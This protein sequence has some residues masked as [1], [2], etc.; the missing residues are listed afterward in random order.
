MTRF[1]I[2]LTFICITFCFYG[3]YLA[4]FEL[5]AVNPS[6]KSNIS[7]FNDYKGV[8]NVHTELSSGSSSA[9]FVNHSAKLAELDFIF[10]TD[11]NIFNNPTTTE[12]YNSDLLSFNAGKYSYLD[13]RLIHYSFSQSPLGSN[14]G[15]AQVRLADILSQK[16]GSNKDDLTILAHPYKA[17]FTWRGELPSGLDGIEILN[18]RSLINRS[19]EESK[20]STLW[21]FVIYP[22]NPKLAFIRLYK[23]PKEELRLWD[24]YTPHRP[25]NGYAGTEASARAIPITNVFLKFPSY[26]RS[27]EFMSNHVVSR[28]ELTGSYQ[29]DKTKIYS[30]LKT[31]QF[32]VAL[33]TL[34]DPQGFEVVLQEKEN[35]YL[36]GSI[37]RLDKDLLLKVKMPEGMNY[38]FEVILYRNGNNIAK[39][40]EKISYFKINDVGA[41]R[42]QVKVAA[43]LPI[44]DAK[45][46]IS[47]IYT[48]PFYITDSK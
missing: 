14:L 43:E 27:F 41:Y 28:S 48:N 36:M 25:L 47:W 30:A 24:E 32:Y 19:W 45:K 3:V 17:G 20:L 35:E 37:V 5:Q 33:D 13:S 7:A 44:P 34:G 23:E 16:V 8:L 1:F 31:G 42:V 15:E 22:F 10:F 39:S 26:K 12:A 4:H 46:W 2:G 38:D 29:S 18:L 9:N 21:S 6:F 40:S 11:L